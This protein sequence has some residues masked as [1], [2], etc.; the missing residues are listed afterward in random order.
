MKNQRS[1][2]ILSIIKHNGYNVSVNFLSDKLGVSPSTI[3]RDLQRLEK[4]NKIK[5]SYG[6]A[7]C[8]EEITDF[9]PFSI[10]FQKNIPEKMAACRLASTLVNEGDTVFVD[11]SSTACCLM[12]FLREKPNIKIITNGIENVNSL[13]QDNVEVYCTGGRLSDV[14]RI[15]FVGKRAI[16]FVK[17]MHANIA[18]SSTFSVSSDGYAYDICDEEIAVR[19]EMLKNSDK[20]VLV[21][22]NKKLGKTAP[23]FFADINSFDYV[24]CNKPISSFFK[25]DIE[26]NFIFET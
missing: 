14:N 26:T 8:L 3:R 1:E 15:A 19:Q 17:S 18:F 4:E 13:I 22:D 23:F 12:R 20:K 10:R 6:K 24:V 11:A 16:D 9:L 5:R 25:E 21:I 2:N 7:E